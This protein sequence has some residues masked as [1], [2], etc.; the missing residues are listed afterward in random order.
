MTDDIYIILYIYIYTERERERFVYG[1]CKYTVN[2]LLHEWM[3]WNLN[4]T[5]FQ[6]VLFAYKE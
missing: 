1:G 6:P 4:M 5:D 3:V 2:I